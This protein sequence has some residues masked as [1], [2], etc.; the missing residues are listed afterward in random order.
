MHKENKALRQL[1]RS[2]VTVTA[3]Q[4]ADYYVKQIFA[5][6]DS[7]TRNQIRAE[8]E[9]M[10]KQGALMKIHSNDRNGK[11][12]TLIMMPEY[13]LAGEPVTIREMVNHPANIHS[14]TYEAIRKRL[15]QG[16]TPDQALSVKQM[17]KGRLKIEIRKLE[18]KKTELFDVDEMRQSWDNKSVVTTNRLPVDNRL[19]TNRLPM[20]TNEL[21]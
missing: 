4:I 16:M 7:Y 15:R 12:L 17:K 11:L 13:T 20:T 3:N 6:D 14:F 10:I 19:T 1:I 2:A 18:S 8:L 21:P 9:E 5:S